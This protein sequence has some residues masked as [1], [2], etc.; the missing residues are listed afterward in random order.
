MDHTC[1]G[2]HGHGADELLEGLGGEVEVQVE[3]VHHQVVEEEGG[4]RQ[5][6][7]GVPYLATGGQVP[8]GQVDRCQVDRWTGARWTGGNRWH[9]L[10][11]QF[12]VDLPLGCFT[13]NPQIRNR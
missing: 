6:V 1:L 3:L 13:S 11:R 7:A 4:V 12:S 5:A 2:P 10:D 9:I 8:G